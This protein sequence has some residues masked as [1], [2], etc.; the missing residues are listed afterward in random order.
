MAGNAKRLRVTHEIFAD[1]VESF[2]HVEGTAVRIASGA[3]MPRGAD[4]VVPLWS[5]DQGAANVGIVQEVNVGDNAPPRGGPGRWRR[6]SWR[7]ERGFFL[8]GISRCLRV[9]VGG[10]TVVHPA[11]RVVVM[12]IGNEQVLQWC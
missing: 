10:G 1:S 7:P 12:S 3:R 5:T 9:P 2:S 8:L 4:A 11:P 6:H